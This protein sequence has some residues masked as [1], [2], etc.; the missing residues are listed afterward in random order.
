MA[1]PS[2]TPSVWKEFTGLV[3][4]RARAVAGI[5]VDMLFLVLWVAG[6]WLFRLATADIS[7]AGAETWAIPVAQGVFAL[8]TLAPILLYIYWDLQ[9]LARR[10][11]DAL[12]G[13]A[14]GGTLRGAR[15]T[16]PVPTLPGA[17]RDGDA[18]EPGRSAPPDR[19]RSR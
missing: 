8:S 5:L 1:T 19:G 10:G 16:E 9:T 6:Q 11:Q 4:T 2:A 3:V 15:P 14:S 7:L 18:A 17:R 12:A 13:E